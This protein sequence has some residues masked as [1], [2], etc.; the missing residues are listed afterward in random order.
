MSEKTYLQ[1]ADEKL[2]DSLNM[3]FKGVTL[4]ELAEV[5]GS[6]ATA[7]R[8]IARLQNAYACNITC[9]DSLYQLEKLGRSNAWL[10]LEAKLIKR[11]LKAKLLKME[12]RVQ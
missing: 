4:H 2:K 11:K 1:E 5:L 10:K 12:S 9:K 7:R 8:Q 3:L 6:E